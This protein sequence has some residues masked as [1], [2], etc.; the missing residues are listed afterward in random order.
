MREFEKN[1][2]FDLSK[3]G[4]FRTLSFTTEM[5]VTYKM[6][7]AITLGQTQAKQQIMKYTYHKKVSI[8]DGVFIFVYIYQ[9]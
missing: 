9:V 7:V 6:Y 4:P 5:N 3:N 8:V 2:V 1:N